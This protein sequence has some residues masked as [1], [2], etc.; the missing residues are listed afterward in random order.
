[1][2]EEIA[3]QAFEPFFTTRAGTGRGLGLVVVRQTVEMLGGHVDVASVSGAGTR[4]SLVV[5]VE[6]RA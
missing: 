2:A 6:V 5:P 4:V 3:A 1:M